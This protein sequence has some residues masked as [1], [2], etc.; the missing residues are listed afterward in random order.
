MWVILLSKLFGSK[1]VIHMRAGHF[2]SNYERSA[3]ILIYYKKSARKVDVGICQ[4]KSLT[5][6]FR[7]IDQD[8]V[9]HVSM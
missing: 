7:L 2:R 1:V 4:S 6:Q 5:N 3:N 8:K 9:K